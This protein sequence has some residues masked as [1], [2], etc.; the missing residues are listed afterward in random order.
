MSKKI[1]KPL[2]KDME[3]QLMELH[4]RELLFIEPTPGYLS[5]AGTSLFKRGL[6]DLKQYTIRNKRF[7]AFRITP[8]GIFYLNEM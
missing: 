4:E 1:L 6:V 8:L 7:Y 2:S 5:R 3:E